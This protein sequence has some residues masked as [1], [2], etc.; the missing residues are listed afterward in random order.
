[1]GD[2]QPLLVVS[3]PSEYS[4]IRITAFRHDSFGRVL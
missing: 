3:K 1:M 2:L 4:Q